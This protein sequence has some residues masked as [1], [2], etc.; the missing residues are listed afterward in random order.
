MLFNKKLLT[1][2]WCMNMYYGMFLFSNLFSFGQVRCWDTFKKWIPWIYIG[3]DRLVY[4]SV[5]KLWSDLISVK[6]NIIW[7]IHVHRFLPVLE[8]ITQVWNKVIKLFS[9]WYGV[10]DDLFRF[11]VSFSFQVAEQLDLNWCKMNFHLL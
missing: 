3:C 9:V 4:W 1:N 8:Q 6:L 2:S 7:L 10:Y 11:W 5:E